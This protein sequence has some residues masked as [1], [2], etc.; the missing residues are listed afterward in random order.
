MSLSV[1]RRGFSASLKGVDLSHRLVHGL[2]CARSPPF[3]PTFQHQL[4]STNMVSIEA[5]HEA[6]EF[7]KLKEF[8]DYR[9][10]ANEY[11]I[12]RSTKRLA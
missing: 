4:F 6:L 8:T 3:I 10:V 12:N 11:V 1:P 7:S 2:G 5:A 9:K